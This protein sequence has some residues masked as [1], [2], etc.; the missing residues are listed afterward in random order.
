MSSVEPSTQEENG[1]TPV[2][3]TQQ[4]SEK[5]QSQQSQPDQHGGTESAQDSQEQ[6]PNLVEYDQLQKEFQEKSRKYLVEQTQHVIIPSFAKWFHLNK[7]HPLEKKSFPDFFSEDSIYKTPQSYKYIRDFIINTF[8]LNPKEYLTITAIRR[9][10]AGDVTNIIRIHQFLEKWGLINY[11]IDPKTKST[12]LGPQYTG[13]FQITLDAPDG[14]IPY[15]SEDTQVVK[16]KG[17]ATTQEGQSS[18]AKQAASTLEPTVKK[19]QTP[20]DTPL[21]LNME[22]RRDIYSTGPTKFG[23]KPQNKVSY[24][25]SICG[26]D[27]T[28][29]RYHNLKLKSYSYNPNSTINNASIL[30]SICYD[31]GLFPS[32]FTSSDFVQFK[33]L[34]EN[35]AWTEQEILLL[36]EGIEMFGTFESTSNLITSGAN[37]NINAQN[38]WNKI[39]EHVSTKSKEQCLTKFL[40]LPIEDKFLHK[41]ISNNAQSKQQP[42]PTLS[43]SGD[44]VDKANLV[45]EIAQRLIQSNQGQDLIKSNSTEYISQSNAEQLDLI[46]QI[47]DLT[48]EKVNLKLGKIDQLQNQLVSITN[49]LQLERKQLQLTRWVQ[50]NKVNKLKSE[51]PELSNV[52]SDL[53]KPVKISDINSGASGNLA[54]KTGRDGNERGDDNEN[55]MDVDGNDDDTTAATSSIDAD[56]VPV[57]ISKPKEY[58]FWSG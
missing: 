45:E 50:L 13:H 47:I 20:V 26:K 1:S 21:S 42:Q 19:E 51:N 27:A 56:S 44:N 39:A 28:E 8:R 30:C 57:S 12:I 10:L 18:E 2:I 23:F 36:L 35:E 5:Q 46:N 3:D 37:I 48:V 32:N 53:M 38:Q 22:I 58:Q 17:E 54:S 41:L 25:C 40:Q 55:A 49:Q 14:L 24:S 52:L 9:N 29:V 15:V 34:A 16:G 7:I 31:Q 11:Q 6:K 4:P 43:N 33:Q